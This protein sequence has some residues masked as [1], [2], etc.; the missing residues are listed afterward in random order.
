M[1][2]HYDVDT[3]LV[4]CF[5]DFGFFCHSFKR[6]GQPVAA[7]VKFNTSCTPAESD[8]HFES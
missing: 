2:I 7:W 6:R 3:D 1:K 5:W 4:G 8:T